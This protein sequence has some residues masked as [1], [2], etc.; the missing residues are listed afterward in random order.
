MDRGPTE[1]QQS[2]DSTCILTTTS[3]SIGMVVPHTTISLRVHSVGYTAIV[4]Y[5]YH[6]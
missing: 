2:Y 4:M 1:T 3:G 6:T 5:I